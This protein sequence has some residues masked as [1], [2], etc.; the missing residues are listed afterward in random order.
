M[1]KEILFRLFRIILVIVFVALLS[2]ARNNVMNNYALANSIMN[3]MPRFKVTEIDNNI[4][5][6]YG[7]KEEHSIKIENYSRTKQD[8]SFILKDTNDSFPFDYMEYTILKNNSIVKTGIVRK[9]ETLYKTTIDSKAID[10]YNII[11]SMNQEDINALGGVSISAQ[12][13]FV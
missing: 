7:L 2:A 6:T 10:M 8:V 9:N 11:L 5:S 1:K 4:D 3:T 13:S 12:I